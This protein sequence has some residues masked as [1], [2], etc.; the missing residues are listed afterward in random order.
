M[1]N[2]FFKRKY[3][4]LLDSVSRLVRWSAL[5]NDHVTL[6]CCFFSAWQLRYRKHETF[7]LRQKRKKEKTVSWKKIT[8]ESHFWSAMDEKDFVDKRRI[9]FRYIYPWT[10]S[11]SFLKMWFKHKAGSCFRSDLWWDCLLRVW[12]HHF[13]EHLWPVS[14]ELKKDVRLAVHT[15]SSKA[16][17]TRGLLTSLHS[18][19][20]SVP[21]IRTTFRG[22]LFLW[23]LTLCAIIVYHPLQVLSVTTRKN[24]L[25]AEHWMITGQWRCWVRSNRQLAS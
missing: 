22:K 9:Y 13:I 15:F 2:L 12:L 4:A 17:N 25:I 14:Q 6:F 10:T 16:L 8:Y 21:S 11:E 19:C 23:Q 24:T 20:T 18:G 3:Q 7:H 5:L 1:V